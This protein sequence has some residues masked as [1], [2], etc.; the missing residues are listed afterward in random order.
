MFFHHRKLIKWKNFNLAN[1]IKPLY[2]PRNLILFFFS[3]IIIM[4]RPPFGVQNSNPSGLRLVVSFTS[5]IS[6]A[7]LARK[8]FLA[9]YASKVKKER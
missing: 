5:P 1:Y 8:S 7:F 3:I 9:G 4:I 2:D 6:A